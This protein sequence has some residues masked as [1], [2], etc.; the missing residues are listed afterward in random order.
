[1]KPIKAVRRPLAAWLLGMAATAVPAVLAAQ[2][3]PA[4]AD[5][6]VIVVAGERYAADGLK[7]RFLGEDYRDL[8]TTPIRVPLLSLAT[9]AGGLTPVERGGGLQTQVLH[10]RTAAGREYVFRSVDKRPHLTKEPALQGTVV[11]DIIQDQ[12]SSLQPAAAVV[13][14]PLLEAVGVLH[15]DPVLVVMPDDPALGKFREEFGGVLGWIEERPDEVEGGEPGFGGFTRITGT[16]RLLERLEESPEDRVAARDYLTAR[17][18]D[19]FLGDWDRHY[20]QWRWAEV[21]RDGV[22]YWLPIPRDRDYAFVNYD[23]WFMRVGRNFFPNGVKFGPDIDNV[24]GLTLNAQELDR[25]LLAELEL[26]EWD[27]V[28]AFVQAR[29]TDSVIDA[30]VRRLPPEYHAV[31]GAE[32]AQTLKARRSDIRTGARAFYKHLASEV[33]VR[34]TDEA[35]VAV[36]ERLADDVVD[37]RLFARAEGAEGGEAAG[38]A[39]FQ[40]RFYAP[41]TTEVRIYLHGGDDYAVVRGD[42][43]ETLMVRVIG[44]GG[45]DVLVDSSTVRTDR[46]ETA[47]YDHRGDNRF[48]RARGTV[49]S[50]HEYDAPDVGTAPISGQGYRDWGSSTSIQPYLNYQDTD[51]LIV[52]GG[53][54]FTRQGFRRAPFAY[55][56][57]A[58]GMVGLGSGN[59]AAEAF[60][61][62][63]RTNSAVTYSVSLLGSQLDNFRFY[64]FGNDTEARAD[65]R[66]YKVQQDQVVL[67]GAVGLPLPGA[68]RLQAGPIVKYTNPDVPDG[69]P[70]GE[71]PRYGNGGFGQ[72]GARAEARFDWRDQS[73]YPRRGAR[74]RANASAYPAVWDAR[75]PFGSALLDATGYLTASWDWPVTLA[76]RAGGERV[77]GEFPVHESAFLGGSRSLRGFGFQRFAGDASLFGGAELRAPLASANLVLLRG[78]LGGLLLADAGRVYFNGE[79]EG[80]WHTAAGAGLWFRFPLR[81]TDYVLSATYAQGEE[82]QV[83]L[84]LGVPF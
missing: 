60:G 81:D 8:W 29:L 74:L 31:R 14:A 39:Y 4:A 56:L 77:W 57:G 80:G 79:S 3:A 13:V 22:S 30:A 28:A 84:K 15:P 64:G 26:A 75:E 55:Q 42:V 11:Q 73:S 20:D 66:L 19:L 70:L 16:E 69:S 32:F 9:Y 40:R 63:N 18:T 65:R 35:D 6:T 76:L 43:G 27:S 10:L 45:D 54:T 36:V 68:G 23:G 1:M 71:L 52:G 5:T 41:E 48:V 17:L 59:V 53:Y 7:A 67:G 62:W 82:G 24:Y 21:E 72:V 12:V 51:G 2:D 34:A 49:V 46:H 83:Y 58:R 38:P 37:V 50:T 78:T 61:V 33:D 25:R 47:F 44:G